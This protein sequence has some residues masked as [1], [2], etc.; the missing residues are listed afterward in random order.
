MKIRVKARKSS[1]YVI[2]L[3]LYHMY[4]EIVQRKFLSVRRSSLNYIKIH[5]I[6]TVNFMYL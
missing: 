2:E 4:I 3:T 6:P 1:E 5:K